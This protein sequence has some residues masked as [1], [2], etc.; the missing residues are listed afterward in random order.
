MYDKK[1]H[2]KVKTKQN[3]FFSIKRNAFPALKIY[4]FM[5]HPNIDFF[6]FERFKKSL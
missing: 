6:W 4:E 2:K 5:N 1:N 3:V